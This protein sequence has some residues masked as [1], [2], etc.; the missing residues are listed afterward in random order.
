MFFET[1][2]RFDVL[3]QRR[4]RIKVFCTEFARAWCN[5]ITIQFRIWEIQQ[6]PSQTFMPKDTT[7]YDIV[8]N[9][10]GE[11]NASRLQMHTRDKFEMSMKNDIRNYEEP[12]LWAGPLLYY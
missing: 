8:H 5:Q 9:T 12:N 3:A 11:G 6:T 1:V 10:S 7:H 4:F 2:T